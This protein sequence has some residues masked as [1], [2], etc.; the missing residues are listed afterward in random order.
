MTDPSAAPGPGTT[1]IRLLPGADEHTGRPVAEDAAGPL[2]FFRQHGSRSYHQFPLD[3]L[4][5][6]FAK[7]AVDAPLREDPTLPAPRWRDFDRGE[8]VVRVYDPRPEIEADNP[9]PGVF[10]FHGGGWV[11]GDVDTHHPIA[12]RWAAR[13]GLP[14][15]AISYR[16]APEHPYP[17]AIE[18]SRAGLAWFLDHSAEHGLKVTSVSLGGDSAGGTLAAVLSNELAAAAAAGGDA[19]PLDSQVL[20]YPAVD[21]SRGGAENPSKRRLERGFPMTTE[22]VGFF[23]DSF[24]PEGVDR[25]ARDIS[26]L[27]HELPAG[28]P[29]SYVLTVDNDPLA[30]E[31]IDY[32]GKLAK[33]GAYVYHEHLPGYAHGIFSSAG[34]IPTGERYI[35]EAADFVAARAGLG[36]ARR[37][38]G[39]GATPT[40]N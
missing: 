33:S 22:T 34:V 27:L 11:M 38:A 19:V 25:T 31:G 10:F 39:R 30:D 21:A 26:P 13:T 29:D 40:Q 37:E 7:I 2:E 32:A 12:N 18:D 35:N 24:L 28:L 20:I 8:F 23:S 3:E 6:A 16:L 15:A 5:A 14:V 17:A 9:T 1:P 4:R 36:R